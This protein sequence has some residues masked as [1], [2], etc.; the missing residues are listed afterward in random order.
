MTAHVAFLSL[1]GIFG[2]PR[3]F[4]TWRPR[5]PGLENRGIDVGSVGQ[6]VTEM[7]TRNFAQ[8]VDQSGTE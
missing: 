6:E 5:S 3:V 2:N 7:G 8:I 4:K 1:L